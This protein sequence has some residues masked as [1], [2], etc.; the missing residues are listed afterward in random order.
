MPLPDGSGAVEFQ[1]MDKPE[2]NKRFVDIFNVNFVTQDDNRIPKLS[3]EGLKSLWDSR[4][5][6]RFSE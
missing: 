6:N 4:N 2:G 3:H 5:K 1:S